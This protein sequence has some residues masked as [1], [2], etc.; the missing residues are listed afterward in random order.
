MRALLGRAGPV[1]VPGSV[2]ALA[3]RGPAEEPPLPG[4]PLPQLVSLFLPEFPVRP[5]ARQ[6]QLKVPSRGPH[7]PTG[8]PVHPNGDPRPSSRRV[9][10]SHRGSPEHPNGSPRTP[11]QGPLT[12]SQGPCTSYWGTLTSP[13]GPCTSYRDPPEPRASSRSIRACCAAIPGLLTVLPA[14]LARLAGSLSI[15]PVSVA[16]PPSPLLPLPGPLLPPPGARALCRVS[17]HSVGVPLRPNGVPYPHSIPYGVPVGSSWS[18]C[19]PITRLGC[20]LPPH[21]PQDPT[22][23]T[24]N[25]SPW[26]AQTLLPL[27]PRS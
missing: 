21:P 1:P 3:P 13:R 16:V 24:P 11:C 7:P 10:G 2:R 12:S 17:V 22:P 9:C 6:Q 4:W 25:P 14:L 23:Y 5:S 18:P 26:G 27:T 8:I 15:L 20:P 19:V